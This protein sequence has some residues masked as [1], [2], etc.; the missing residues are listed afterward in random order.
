MHPPGIGCG[1]STTDFRL[2]LNENLDKCIAR[3]SCLTFERGS[4]RGN[5]SPS[6]SE[7]ASLEAMMGYEFRVFSLEVWGCGGQTALNA[8]V[9]IMCIVKFS[10]TSPTICVFSIMSI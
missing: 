4:L 7:T 3:D 5:S 8:Q 1:G 10:S 6:K 2:W 9:R